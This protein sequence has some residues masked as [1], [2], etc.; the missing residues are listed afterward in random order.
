[1]SSWAI[2][3]GDSRSDYKSHRLP[4]QNVVLPEIDVS[5]L[6]SSL[7]NGGQCQPVHTIFGL[8]SLPLTHQCY[9]TRGGKKFEPRRSELNKKRL[10]GRIIHNLQP[11]NFGGS[12]LW[13]SIQTSMFVKHH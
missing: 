9:Y 2:N 5:S 10:I 3:V 11:T 7:G 12:I 4:G 8:K 13:H 1:M 6:L